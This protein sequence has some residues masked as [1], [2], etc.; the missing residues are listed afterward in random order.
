MPCQRNGNILSPLRSCNEELLVEELS[1]DEELSEELLEL[2]DVLLD[3]R[4]D[5][6]CEDELELSTLDELEEYIK[7]DDEV[8]SAIFAL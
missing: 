5:R 8:V 3:D 7:L 4:L 1:I 6:D 2:L